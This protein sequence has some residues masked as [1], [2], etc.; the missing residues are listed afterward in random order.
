MQGHT[1]FPHALQKRLYYL[2]SILRD[3]EDALIFLRDKLDAFLLKPIHRVLL[4]PMSQSTLHE[5]LA[6]RICL[7]ELLDLS[8]GIGQVAAATASHSNFCKW[9]FACLEDFNNSLRQL[10]FQQDRTKAPCC[11]GTDDANLHC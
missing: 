7:L 6:T 2:H 10:A 4:A 5:L 11:S 9:T 8:E 3:W 1:F